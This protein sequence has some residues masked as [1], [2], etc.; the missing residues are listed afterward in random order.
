MP[1]PSDVGII[2]KVS[3]QSRRRERMASTARRKA[4]HREVLQEEREGCLSG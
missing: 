4:T 3:G 1:V 2:D